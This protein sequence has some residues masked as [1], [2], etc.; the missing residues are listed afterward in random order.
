MNNKQL[1]KHHLN[2]Y[3]SDVIEDISQ[4]YALGMFSDISD[5]Y[6]KS[7]PETIK[8][9]MTRLVKQFLKTLK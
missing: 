9:E 5:K 6:P 4:G 1:A 3:L 7:N 8:K 2:E